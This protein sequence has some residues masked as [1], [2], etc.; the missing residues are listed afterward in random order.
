[1]VMISFG[2]YQ[3]S[4]ISKPMSYRIYQRFIVWNWGQQFIE[5]IYPSQ[6]AS[7]ATVSCPLDALMCQISYH[8]KLF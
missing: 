8:M 3:Y 5:E 4:D 7:A 2:E 6:R 1:M